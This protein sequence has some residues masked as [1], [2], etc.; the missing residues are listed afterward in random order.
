MTASDTALRVREVLTWLE[1][2]SSKKNRDGTSMYSDESVGLVLAII[3]P[4]IGLLF[5]IYM[6]SQRNPFGNRII[7]VSVIAAVVW[8]ILV[9]TI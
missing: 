9:F 7:I 4:F 3:V 5:G 6:K 8:G 2:R 1:R